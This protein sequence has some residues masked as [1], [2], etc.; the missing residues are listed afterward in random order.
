MYRLLICCAVVG[1][2]LVPSLVQAEKPGKTVIAHIGD[3]AVTAEEPIMEGD[4]EI[5]VRYTV[6]GYYNVIEVSDKALKA[7]EGHSI[8]MK[9]E[10]FTDYIPYDGTKGDHF[11]EDRVVDVL[12]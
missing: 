4:V 8:E 3:V 10:V 6:T 7:H 1:A 5:G 12:N 9:G 11:N 2:L